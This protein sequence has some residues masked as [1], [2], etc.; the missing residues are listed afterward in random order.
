MSKIITLEMFTE[1]LEN[2]VGKDYSVIEYNPGKY[3]QS[4][5]QHSRCGKIFEITNK[6][7]YNATYEN[8]K[9]RCP[10]CFNNHSRYGTDKVQHIINSLLD[11]SYIVEKYE[12]KRFPIELFHKKCNSR[13]ELYLGNIQK[14]Q[15]CPVCESGFKKLSEDKK[16]KFED[17]EKVVDEKSSGKIKL[18]TYNGYKERCIFHCSDCNNNF[19]TTPTN[20]IRGTRCPFCSATSG[21]QEIIR[22]LNLHN[23][24]FEFQKPIKINEKYYFFDF[25]IPSLNV[26]LEFDGKQ[27]FKPAFGKTDLEK[28]EALEKTMSRDEIKNN[29][30]KENN[31]SIIR[32]PYNKVTKID[33]ILNENKIYSSTTIENNNKCNSKKRE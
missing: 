21:E 1:R 26:V 18:I 33:N 22:L 11:D 12:N 25:Y 31:I 20:F 17:F 4:K 28:L 15:R 13:I 3:S 32:I 24:S 23:I 2:N 27:H 19:E 6:E 10:F 29:Y 30:C 8:H 14:G 9:A 5:I 7:I 16:Y